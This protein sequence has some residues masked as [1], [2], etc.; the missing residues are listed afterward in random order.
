MIPSRRRGACPGLSTPMPTGDGLLARLLPIGTIALD[1][2]AGLAAA[3]RAHGNGIVEITARGSIQIRGLTPASAPAFADAAAGLGIAANEGV[4]VIADPLAGLDPSEA[5]DASV[6]AAELRRALAAQ[7]FTAMLAPKVC[8]VIDGG[9]RL[10]LDALSADVRLCAEATERG[11]RIHVAVAG[12][13]ATATP[14]G[15]IEPTHAVETVVRLLGIIATH[16]RAARARDVD[17]WMPDRRAAR[18]IRDDNGNVIGIHQLRGNQVALGIGFAFGHAEASALE[19][20]IQAARDAGATGFRAAPGRALLMIGLA[21]DRVAPLIAAATTLGFIVDAGDLRRRVVACAGAPLC[22]S[23]EIP[24]RALASKLMAAAALLDD[25]EVIHVSGCAKGCAH[26][27]ATALTAI[28]RAGQ[29]DLLWRGAPAGSVA[30]EALPQSLAQL[31][32]RPRRA[33]H[34]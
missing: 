17:T 23:A 29:C 32:Q 24:T 2:F 8:V 15:V 33:A 18:T 9:G 11:A 12:N 6:L 14:I 25:G 4:P 22:A 7:A 27:G 28:G 31:A 1:A 19:A 16:G 20:L 13:A 10:H 30:V 34:G 3:A 5:L 21:P 26:R